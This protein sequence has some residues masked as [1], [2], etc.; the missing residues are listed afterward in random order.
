MLTK[1]I[2]TASR[3]G[4]NAGRSVTMRRTWYAEDKPAEGETKPDP[5]KPEGEKTPP[6]TFDEKYVQDLRDEAA[7]WRKKLREMEVKLNER[8]TTEKTA[9]EKELADQQQYKTLAEQRAQE[10]ADIKAENARLQKS[11]L[12]QKVAAEVGLPPKFADRL[13]GSTEEEMKADA[14]DLKKELPAAQ[15]QQ[16]TQTQRTTTSF[17]G[18]KP[19]A[20]TDEQRRAR[21]YGGNK[22]AFGS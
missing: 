14:E 17:P 15:Q 19:G 21:L 20:E 12:Q 18:G 11:A 1:R 6:K 9:K 10:L 7:G 4:P 2:R 8:E 13:K 3:F 5:A 22:R 16:T